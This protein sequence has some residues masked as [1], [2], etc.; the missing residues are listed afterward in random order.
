MSRLRSLLHRWFPEVQNPR[1]IRRG[2]SVEELEARC[3]LD[4]GGWTVGSGSGQAERFITGLYQD[5]LQRQASPDEVTSG[6]NA[7]QA[8]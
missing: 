7:L 8:G 2:L 1:P 5:L 6:V 4:G 3:L